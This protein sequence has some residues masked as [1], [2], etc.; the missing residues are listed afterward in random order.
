MY[1]LPSFLFTLL[2]SVTVAFHAIIPKS[3]WEWSEHCRLGIRFI[4]E[5]DTEKIFN[6][7]QYSWYEYHLYN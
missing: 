1:H 6:T 4:G 7:D 5:D 2:C 3:V